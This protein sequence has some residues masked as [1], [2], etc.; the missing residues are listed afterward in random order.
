[1]VEY[2]G[3]ILDEKNVM[4]LIWPLIVFHRKCH[5]CFRCLSV[6]RSGFVCVRRGFCS[7]V[8]VWVREQGMLIPFSASVGHPSP[9]RLPAVAVRCQARILS[10]CWLFWS[11]CLFVFSLHYLSAGILTHL[12]QDAVKSAWMCEVDWDE[13]SD[14]CRVLTR[15]G[16]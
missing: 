9:F 6:L 1:M 13:H 15:L 7:C 4:Q 16:W 8:T 11:D 14:A 2:R 5:W 10:S 3:I 12:H